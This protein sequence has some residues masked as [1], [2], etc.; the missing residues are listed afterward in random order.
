MKRE[1]TNSTIPCCASNHY[2]ILSA[3]FFLHQPQKKYAAPPQSSSASST[4]YIHPCN[5]PTLKATNP[6]RA[7]AKEPLNMN[8]RRYVL[9]PFLA[10]YLHKPCFQYNNTANEYYSSSWFIKSINTAAV[11][12]AVEEEKEET[13]LSSFIVITANHVRRTATSLIFTIL[14]N[15]PFYIPPRNKLSLNRCARDH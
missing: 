2:Y 7:S 3:T 1:A 6:S 15:I 10:I 11:L 4:Q 14:L 9:Y 12:A 13:S 5:V 8:Y